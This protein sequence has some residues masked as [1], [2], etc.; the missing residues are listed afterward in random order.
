VEEKSVFTSQTMCQKMQVVWKGGK[1]A[2]LAAAAAVDKF[3]DD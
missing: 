1:P 3:S 2:A